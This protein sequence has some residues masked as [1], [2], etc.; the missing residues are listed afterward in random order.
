M[1]IE[2]IGEPIRVLVD[3]SGGRAEPLR[4]RWG[5][6]TY[7]I[8]GVNGRWID[9]GG[10]GYRLHYSVQADDQTW[11]LHFASRDVQWWLDQVIVE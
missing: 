4:F 8:S 11:Y 1:N 2:A 10:D 6:R 9:R 5:G 7:K 3:F